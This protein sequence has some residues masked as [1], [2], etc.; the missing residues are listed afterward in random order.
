[1]LADGSGVAYG[2]YNDTSDRVVLRNNDLV[3][4]TSVDIALICAGA[5]GRARDNV[6]SGFDN[7]I[8]GCGNSSGNVIKP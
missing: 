5:N 6:L 4:G 2:M 7:A 3:G 8:V 1:V